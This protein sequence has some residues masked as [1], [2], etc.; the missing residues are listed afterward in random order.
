M[1]APQT[2]LHQRAPL[3]PKHPIALWASTLQTCAP[4][5]PCRTPSAASTA[6]HVRTASTTV[7][8]LWGPLSS[9]PAPER[10]SCH[11]LTTTTACC[12]TR[13][14]MDSMPPM[15]SDATG[16]AYGRTTLTAP[17]ADHAPLATR[18]HSPATAPPSTTPARSSARIASRGN[19]RH[20]NGMK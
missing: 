11:L 14:R 3:A 4:A 6:S 19:T 20:P 2:R 18:T 12:A 15:S 7:C 5:P 13:V 10:A 9:R 17:T 16:A 8:S 1:G